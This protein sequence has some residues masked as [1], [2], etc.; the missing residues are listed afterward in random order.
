MVMSKFESSE[1][2]QSIM[3]LYLKNVER[4]LEAAAASESTASLPCKVQL[5]YALFRHVSERRTV[6]PLRRTE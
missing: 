2:C 4:E 5:L 6:V 3:D 1:G